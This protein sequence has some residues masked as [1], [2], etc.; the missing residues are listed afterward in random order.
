MQ[1]GIDSRGHQRRQP[2]NARKVCRAGPQHGGAVADPVGQPTGDR[3]AGEKLHGQQIVAQGLHGLAGAM[4]DLIA[5][6]A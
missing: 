4:S 2:A 5:V 6:S 3:D 1:R